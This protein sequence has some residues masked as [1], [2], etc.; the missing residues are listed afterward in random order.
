[1]K[2]VILILTILLTAFVFGCSQ[3]VKQTN[4]EIKATKIIEIV[5]NPQLYE[6]KEVI[7]DGKFG[8]WGNSEICLN[9]Y[10]KIT[11]RTRSDVLIYDD[12]GCLYLGDVEVI[13]GKMSTGWNNETI[14]KPLIVK[15][16]IVLIEGKPIL[17]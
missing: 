1:M 15:G 10:N 5:N 12:S 17:G 14:G 4:Q 13:E 2:K 6:G 11:S 16:K 8:G 7:I 3:T 9:T